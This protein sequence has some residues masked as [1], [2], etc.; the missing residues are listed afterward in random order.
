[1]DQPLLLCGVR[2]K[3]YGRTERR[4]GRCDCRDTHERHIWNN[5]TFVMIC[6]QPQIITNVALLQMWRRRR[7]RGRIALDRRV[8]AT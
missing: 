1:M 5:A 4:F 7:T 8:G 3:L 2:S 6:G